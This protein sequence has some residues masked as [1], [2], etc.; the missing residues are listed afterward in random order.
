MFCKISKI[1][2]SAF[3]NPHQT[4][5]C[6]IGGGRSMW[7]C[8]TCL[9]FLGEEELRE[10]RPDVNELVFNANVSLQN[11]LPEGISADQKYEVL[12]M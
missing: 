11:L 12:T 6:L 3:K 4:Q 10:S 9:T 7:L 1:S 8:S 2:L 5:W